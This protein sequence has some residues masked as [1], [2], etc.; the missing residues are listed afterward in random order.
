MNR[1]A[2]LLASALALAAAVPAA[3]GQAGP[4]TISV[5]ASTTALDQH[6][7]RTAGTFM[8]SGRFADAGTVSTSYRFA[9]PDVDG[10]ATLSGARGIFTIALQ[11]TVGRVVDGRQNAGGRWRLRGGTGRYKRAAGGGR[12]ETVA[13]FGSAPPGMLL[14]EMHGA[15]FGRLARGSAARH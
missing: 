13:D 5:Q 10:M 1:A 3:A 11:G 12:W 8:M 14:P 7:G 6:G 4:V 2:L 9:G 15:F